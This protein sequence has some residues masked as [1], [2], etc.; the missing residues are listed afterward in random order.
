MPVEK[1]SSAPKRRRNAVATREAILLSA[2]K[3]F[4]ELG[5]DGAG[6][7]EIAK[8]AGVTAMMVNRYFGSK[9]QLFAE[10]AAATMSDPMILTPEIIHTPGFAENMARSLVAITARD[11]VPMEGFQI[12]LKSASSPR[13]AEIGRKQIE[14]QHL[15]AMAGGLSGDMVSQR[16]AMVLSIVAGIQVMRHMIGLKALTKADPEAL[17]GLL[18][19]IF[20][21]LIVGEAPAKKPTRRGNKN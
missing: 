19:P 21:H 12:M 7:R 11:A 3:A 8:G 14:T 10:V 18:T 9:E 5:Y 13:A 6:V 2:R 4:A 16:A 15:K 17:V 1:T 20:Q